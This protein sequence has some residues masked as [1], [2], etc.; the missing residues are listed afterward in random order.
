[1]IKYL[2][3]FT[4]GLYVGSK[5]TQVEALIE[6]PKP[7]TQAPLKV[8]DVIVVGPKA[9]PERGA[10]NWNYEWDDLEHAETFETIAVVE[11]GRYSD[12][13]RKDLNGGIYYFGRYFNTCPS[14]PQEFE[15][16]E[17]DDP[18]FPDG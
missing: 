13:Y 6:N 4:L 3:V 11:N 10:S 5:H 14:E 12:I 2:F 7:L 18:E 16:E 9:C 8:V 17:S 15:P 1:M